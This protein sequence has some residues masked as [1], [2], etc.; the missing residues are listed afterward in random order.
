MRLQAIARRA[1]DDGFDPSFVAV[2]LISDWM[3]YLDAIQPVAS[4]E[5]RLP[6]AL[7]RNLGHRLQLLE[8]ETAL[9]LLD[10]DT[11]RSFP[12]CSTLFETASVF[13]IHQFTV[14]TNTVLEG[15]GAH[16]YRV[17]RVAAGETP[18]NRLTAD[19][20][21][22]ALIRDVLGRED[23]PIAEAQLSAD[24]R[25]LTDWR[26]L[27]HLDRPSEDIHF[28]EFTYDAC[29]IPAYKTFRVV[30][31][32]LNPDFPETCLNEELD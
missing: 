26:N 18:R 31:K 17:Q 7:R 29:F 8:F 4:S 11:K 32:A 25:Q 10:L 9:L 27:A 16:F 3:A 21:R 14:L 30:L 28:N 1:D 19:E 5:A 24:V 23:F 2:N 6:A 12:G 13:K 22:I 20:W 15:I